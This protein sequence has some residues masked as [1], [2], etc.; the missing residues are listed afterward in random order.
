M[1]N[2]VRGKV[3]KEKLGE[4]IK[5]VGGNCAKENSEETINTAIGGRGQIR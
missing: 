3:H 4:I 1:K 2:N 5:T